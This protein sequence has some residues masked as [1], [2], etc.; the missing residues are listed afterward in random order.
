MIK[1]KSTSSGAASASVALTDQK[2][3]DQDSCYN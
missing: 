1:L 2:K 3:N